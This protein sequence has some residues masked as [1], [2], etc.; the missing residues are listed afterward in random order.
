[1]S[2]F[3]PSSG[4]FVR[5]ANLWLD[6]SS[7]IAIGYVALVGYQTVSQNLV[8]MEFLVLNGNYNADRVDGGH[9]SFQILE[10]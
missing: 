6:K 2:A 4:G 7:S 8:Q 5:H 3:R 1:M 10:P 9:D